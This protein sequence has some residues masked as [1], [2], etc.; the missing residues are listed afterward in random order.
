MATKT[1]TEIN[2]KKYYRITRTIGHEIKD[3]KKIPIKKQFLGT[4]KTN[5]E[6]KFEAWKDE[7][8]NRKTQEQIDAEKRKDKTFGELAEY[9]MENVFKLSSSYAFGTKRR[10]EQSYRV[11][12]KPSFIMGIPIR[13]V[14]AMTIQ[15]L[16]NSLDVSMQN[17]KAISKFMSV[18][19]KWLQLNEYADNILT[20]VTLPEKYD[21]S[22]DDEIVVWE[23]EEIKQILTLSSGHRMHIAFVLMYYAGL[24]ISECLGLKY[25]D[26]KNGMLS[27]NRQ[28]YQGTLLEPKY[29]SFRKIPVHAELAK[30][31]E[32]H[33]IWHKQEMQSNGYITD[34]I[35]TTTS[36]KLY[37][38]GNARRAFVR[39]YK[40]HGIPEKKIHAYRATFCTELCRAG[41][42][43]EVA[44][45]LM[46]HKSV[47]VT[48]KHYALVKDDFKI[49]AINMLPNMMTSSTAKPQLR[50]VKP[51]KMPRRIK[52]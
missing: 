42:P 39:F 20:A 24:R 27:V 41:V 28:Y 29:K 45:K 33:K 8:K 6:K 9:F 18:F 1:N 31:L 44:S 36:G 17:L 5:A 30:E 12:I 15:D 35:L 22:K 47:E 23:S 50:V 7:Q 19:F 26:I 11:H 48:A 25:S 46:G 4:S 14:R 49:I 13:N 51:K 40:K 34:F 38:Y 10:Y 43:L 2:G 52:I 37:E 21:N 32:L 3:G 16:Y